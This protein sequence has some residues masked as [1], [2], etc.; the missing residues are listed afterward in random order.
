MDSNG[1]TGR[2]PGRASASKWKPRRAA[3]PSA[4]GDGGRSRDGR[5]SG[6]GARTRCSDAVTAV[7]VGTAVGRFGCW[8]GVCDVTSA[9]PP[10]PSVNNW[11]WF[12]ESSR[13]PKH[14]VNFDGGDGRCWK[15]VVGGGDE[16]ETATP[17]LDEL[18]MFL[19][20]WR[21]Y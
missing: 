13:D 9:P 3:R 21:C 14:P 7:G 18:R 2:T 20:Q 5:R 1:I 4:R 12:G 17:S 6:D 15:V 8:R 11:N 10:P 16:D 19:C